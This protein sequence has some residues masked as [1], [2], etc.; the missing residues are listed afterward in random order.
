MGANIR[1]FGQ[2][3]GQSNLEHIHFLPVQSF[4]YRGVTGLTGYT[5]KG[6]KYHGAHLYSLVISMKFTNQMITIC[7]VFSV[8]NS[9]RRSS[10]WTPAGLHSSGEKGHKKTDVKH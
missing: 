3:A 1:W 7:S 9:V 5:K 4:Y 2:Q 10:S 6:I 8:S